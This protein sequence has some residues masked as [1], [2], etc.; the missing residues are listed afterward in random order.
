MLPVVST[1]LPVASTG[2]FRASQALFAGEPRRVVVGS[3]IIV[4]VQGIDQDEFIVAASTL[5]YEA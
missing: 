5:N 3:G 2:S 4:L 1:V